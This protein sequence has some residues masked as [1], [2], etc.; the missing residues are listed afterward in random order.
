MYVVSR[1]GLTHRA[2]PVDPRAVPEVV[3]LTG[4]FVVNKG[5]DERHDTRQGV[6]DERESAAR[7]LS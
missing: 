6:D 1:L 5:H 2:N 7:R 4:P 3:V